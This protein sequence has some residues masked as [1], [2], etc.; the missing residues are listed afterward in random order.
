MLL[1]LLWLLHVLALGHRYHAR[2]S[3]LGREKRWWLLL[4]YDHLSDRGT[5]GCKVRRGLLEAFPDL[6]CT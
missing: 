4:L 1:K 6:H 5:H 2:R 3:K